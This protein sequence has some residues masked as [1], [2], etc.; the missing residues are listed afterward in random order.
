MKMNLKSMRKYML[1]NKVFL[2]LLYSDSKK[3]TASR[4]TTATVFQLDVV[5]YILHH[6][7]NGRIPL[8]TK[9]YLVLRKA[10]K[11]KTLQKVE[12]EESLIE[13]ICKYGEFCA[14]SAFIAFL[15]ELCIF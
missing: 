14:I 1:R 7:T 10:R 15:A 3:N 6:I 2:H 8:S 12:S 9:D 5:V 13:S 4:L 11:I